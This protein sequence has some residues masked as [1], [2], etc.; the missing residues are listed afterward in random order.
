LHAL[1][2][3]VADVWSALGVGLAAAYRVGSTTFLYHATLLYKS[4]VVMRGGQD[5]ILVI[6]DVLCWK[7]DSLGLRILPYLTTVS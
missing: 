4:I 1:C 6:V 7:V 3:A 2:L 5:G